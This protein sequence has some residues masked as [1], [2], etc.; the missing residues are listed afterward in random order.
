MPRKKLIKTTAAPPT[1]KESKKLPLMPG[2]GVEKDISDG[3]P[4]SMPPTSITTLSVAYAPSAKVGLGMYATGAAMLPLP[5]T[6]GMFCCW[7]IYP[8]W[9]MQRIQRIQNTK[10][11]CPK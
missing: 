2:C 1:A 8:V 9:P 3:M 7:R 6:E 10:L 5:T 4:P 11:S